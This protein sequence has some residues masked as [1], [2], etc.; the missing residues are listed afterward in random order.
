MQTNKDQDNETNRQNDNEIDFGLFAFGKLKIIDTARGNYERIT[1]LVDTALEREGIPLTSLAYEDKA[2][3]EEA[4]SRYDAGWDVVTG[5]SWVMPTRPGQPFLFKASDARHAG[6]YQTYS[7]LWPVTK[8]Q[9]A[10]NSCT[11]Y[12]G[13][14][15]LCKHV[16]AAM[17]IF[18]ACIIF[19]EEY[20]RKLE[21]E[22]LTS[23]GS[24]EKRPALLRVSGPNGCRVIPIS[25]AKAFLGE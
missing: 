11:C 19:R 22:K 21:I 17:V 7:K 14:H 6:P 12:D 5:V 2:R 1:A 9:T 23:Q 10:E 15:R 4:G 25:E 18:F 13:S 24:E 20:K 8:E 16:V 3:G